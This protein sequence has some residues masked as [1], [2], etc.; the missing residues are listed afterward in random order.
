LNRLIHGVKVMTD[1]RTFVDLIGEATRQN[2]RKSVLQAPQPATND[3]RRL[4]HWPPPQHA[5]WRLEKLTPWK[6]KPW[7]TDD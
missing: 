4:S 5:Q 2:R 1:K 3:K 6:L 7:R